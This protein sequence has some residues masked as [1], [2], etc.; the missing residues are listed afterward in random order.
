MAASLIEIHEV[1]KTYDSTAALKNVSINID[2][3]ELL[4]LLGSSGS[5]KSTLLKMI[6]GLVVPTSGTVYF[7]GEAVTNRDPVKLRRSMGYVFQQV[8]LFPHLSVFENVSLVLGLQGASDEHCLH[9]VSEVLT[10]VDLD[11]EIFTNRFPSELSGGELQRV[12]VARALAT[13]PD[14]ILMDEPFGAVDTIT[15]DGLQQE[16]L[17]LREGRERTIVFVTHDLFEAL[18][19]ADRIAVLHEGRLEQIG[20]PRE[21]MLEPATRFVRELFARPLDQLRELGLTK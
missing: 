8:G 13:D 10:Q 2:K 15:R 21:V 11:P 16:V 6:N 3:G 4:V 14:C 20:S 12:G 5:G 17:K 18:T 19:L 7:A 1:S 9:R